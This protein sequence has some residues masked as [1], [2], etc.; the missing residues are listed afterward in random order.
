M[1]TLPSD[2]WSSLQGGMRQRKSS[3][4]HPGPGGRIVLGRGRVCL[5]AHQAIGDEFSELRLSPRPGGSRI[6]AS[7]CHA[8]YAPIVLTVDIGGVV[9]RQVD[10]ERRYVKCGPFRLA[11]GRTCFGLVH[12]APRFVFVGQ[13]TVSDGENCVDPY[14]IRSEIESSAEGQTDSSRLAA[15]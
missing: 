4:P 1:E 10:Q 7:A 8:P 2:P 15:V 11:H 14:A 3:F 5:V 13:A 12:V 9:G 6:S